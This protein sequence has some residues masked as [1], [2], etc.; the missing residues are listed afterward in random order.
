MGT[1]IL[2][3]K[4]DYNH[5]NVLV[6][7][8][9]MSDR[10][11][12]ISPFLSPDMPGLLADMPSIKRIEL[13]TNLDGYGIAPSVL[14]SIIGLYEYGRDQGID[15]TVKYNNH[16][17][18]KAYLLYK[19]AESQ[20][21]LI[22]SGNFTDNGLKHNHEYGVFLD[23]G[24]LQKELADQI[25]ELHWIELSFKDVI[26]LNKR[27]EEFMKEH[28]VVRQP[29][30]MAGDYISDRIIMPDNCKYFVK[31]LG[32]KNRLVEKGYT[33]IDNNY[34]G[35]SEKQFKQFDVS[36]GDFFICYA[37]EK[38]NILGICQVLEKG[39]KMPPAFEGDRWNYKYKTECI[40]KKYS[41]YWW[42]YELKAFSLAGEFNGSKKQEEHVNNKGTV[43]L[44]ALKFGQQA[45]RVP[46]EFAQFIMD[47]IGNLQ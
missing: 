34:I 33:V 38:G 42:E 43:S 32:N 3:N 6:K 40:T 19:G 29:L 14:S 11:V 9:A 23:N 36:K 5:Y 2:S 28:M 15:V 39:Q 16:L 7:Y 46:R 41:R 30:F 17:H 18:G 1:M 22:T 21:F 45:V 25:T 37:V 10:L 47:K 27:A 4:G 26:S 13:Y 44:G 24:I 20:G 31:P 35:F 8:S 12:I